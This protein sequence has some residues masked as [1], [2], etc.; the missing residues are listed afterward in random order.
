[1]FVSDALALAEGSTGVNDDG[2]RR[3]RWMWNTAEKEGARRCRN[4]FL[5]VSRSERLSDG[6]RRSSKHARMRVKDVKRLIT[7]HS[8]APALTGDQSASLLIKSRL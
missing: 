3:R 1:M 2:S 7:T 5:L 6:S 8:P 4:D